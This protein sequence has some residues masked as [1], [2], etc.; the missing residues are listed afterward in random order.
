[1]TWNE[2]QSANKGMYD[3]TGMSDAW[4]KYKEANGIAYETTRSQTTKSIFLKELGASGKAPK[5]MN[6][7][8]SEGKV[9]P[10]YEV[11]HKVPLSIGG[12]DIPSNMRLLDEAFHKLHHSKGFY[13][14]WQ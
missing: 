11:G 3:N 13:R 8:L 7:W 14:P 9:P 4:T 5:W 12:E 6:Q 2:F 1:M 10:G